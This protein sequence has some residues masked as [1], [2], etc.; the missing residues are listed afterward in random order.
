MT[1]GDVVVGEPVG[2]LVI[3]RFV[4]RIVVGVLRGAFVG[5]LEGFGRGLLVGVIVV[6]GF[7]V[8][9]DVAVLLLR[10]PCLLP[11]EPSQDITPFIDFFGPHP[12]FPLPFRSR[13]ATPDSTISK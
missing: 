12:F 10:P 5:F 7:I 9:V 3:G 6:T 11:F 2:A 4:G 1:T 13:A 8:H